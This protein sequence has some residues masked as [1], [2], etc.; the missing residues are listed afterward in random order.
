VDYSWPGNVRELKNAIEH[1]FVTV[2]GE[3][4]LTEDFPVEVRRA[5]PAEHLPAPRSGEPGDRERILDALQKSGGRKSDAARRLG[6]SRVTLWHRMRMLGIEAER[7]E[8][9]KR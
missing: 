8:A 5:A 4:L 9:R 1:A 7:A 3:V 6:I 2:R